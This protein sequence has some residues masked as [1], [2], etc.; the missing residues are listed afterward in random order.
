MDFGPFPNIYIGKSNQCNQST[1]D[2]LKSLSKRA[3]Q[4]TAEVVGD[5]IGNQTV[6]KI[7]KMSKTSRQNNSKIFKNEHFKEIPKERYI[8]PEERQKITDDL[9]LI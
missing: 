5:L 6:G 7:T 4:K 2:T 9:R 8:S 1:T 3:I